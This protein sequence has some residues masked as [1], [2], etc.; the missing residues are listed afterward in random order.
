MAQSSLNIRIDENDKR[1]F[2]KFCSDVGM[3][4][5]TA[6]SMFIKNVNARQKLPFEVSALDENGFTPEEAA[7][8]SRRI[9]D[10]KAGRVLVQTY[11]EWQGMQ[12]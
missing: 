9:E 4:M 7:E 10:V 8:I 5:S 3:S 1:I 6:V 12:R 2:E 11:E